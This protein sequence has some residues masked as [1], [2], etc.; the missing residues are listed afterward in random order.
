MSR[1]GKAPI[2][3]PS[4]VDVNVN[5]STV[6][7][8]GPK[9][10]LAWEIHED[11]R[12][13]VADGE[14]VVTRPN[15]IEHIF[16][17][18]TQMPDMQNEIFEAI[19]FDERCRIAVQKMRRNTIVQHPDFCDREIVTLSQ[20]FAFGDGIREHHFRPVANVPGESPLPPNTLPNSPGQQIDPADCPDNFGVA[21]AVK[22]RVHDK[23]DVLIFQ[24]SRQIVNRKIRPKQMHQIAIEQL[25]AGIPHIKQLHIDIQIPEVCGQRFNFDIRSAAVQRNAFVGCKYNFHS[26]LFNC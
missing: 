24:V 25:L 4:G 23:F 20:Q 17:R 7:V 5:G 14:I 15:K 12:V 8:K 19:F 26:E 21:A 9:G 22:N 10:Q 3:I 11:V 6:N 13:S 1:I 16:A 18:R 2:A